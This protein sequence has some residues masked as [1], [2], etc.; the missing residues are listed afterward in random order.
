MCV[1]FTN[2]NS[3]CSKNSHPLPSIGN[4]IYKSSGCELLSFMNSYSGYNH[5][6]MRREDEEKITFI[7]E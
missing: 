6:N 1:D 3:A 5:V 2:L 4:L 7:M